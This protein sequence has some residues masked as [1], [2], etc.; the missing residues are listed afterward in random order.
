MGINS[1]NPNA[2]SSPVQVGTDTNW[3]IPLTVG[4]ERAGALK[5]D[6][7][8]W[9]W[10]KNNNGSLGVNDRTHRS[11]PTQVPGTYLAGDVRG[12]ISAGTGGPI[13]MRP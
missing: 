12:A 9:V 5:T 1:T 13:V 8:L 11:S 4:G 2:Y 6:G 7:T 3:D 10:G